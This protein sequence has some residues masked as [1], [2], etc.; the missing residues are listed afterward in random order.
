MPT[1]TELITPIHHVHNNLYLKQSRT[2]CEHDGFAS[3]DSSECGYRDTWRGRYI[4]LIINGDEEIP[5]TH[6][7]AALGRAKERKVRH[8]GV[9]VS[10]VAQ[11]KAETLES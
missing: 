2:E 10:V 1:S 7:P 11:L 8:D 6:T 4:D 3:H 5:D 9:A